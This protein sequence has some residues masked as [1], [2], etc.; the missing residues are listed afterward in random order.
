MAHDLKLNVVLASPGLSGKQLFFAVWY[1]TN[2]KNNIK[3]IS[4]AIPI[5]FAAYVGIQLFVPGSIGNK[6][7]EVEIPEGSTFKQALGI[8]EDNNLIRDRNLFLIMGKVAGLDRRIRAGYYSFSGTMSPWEVFTQLRDGRIVYYEIT[9]VEGESLL[10]I[11]SRLSSRKI[12]PRD[13]FDRL[14][15]DKEF[16]TILD[17]NAPSLEGYLYPQTYKF[18]KGASPESVLKIMVQE[19]RREFTDQ[20]Q[21][22]MR[23]MGWTENDVLTLASIIER[24]AATDEER[25]VISAVYHN[26]INRGMP[27]QADPTAIYGVK[28]YKDKITKDDLRKETAFN[29]YVIK[30]L[31]PGPIASPGMKSI[32][33]AL[34]PA[35]VPYLYFVAKKDGTHYF[36]KTFSEHATAIQRVKEA[37]AGES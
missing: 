14:V 27:L 7:I 20:M 17:I 32:T 5:F 9:I 2:M 33:A 31:P 25:P 24:E 12:V 34:Y 1:S 21:T 30:G 13:A 15:K 35:D 29:T 26:R 28:S 23:E 8:L 11:G 36:S 18:P 10:E 4:A 16:L 6:Q 22:R 19:M 37:H 3:F